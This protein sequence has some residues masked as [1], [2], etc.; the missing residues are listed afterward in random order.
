MLYR[1][2]LHFHRGKGMKWQQSL[3]D[4][5]VQVVR[6]LYSL[7]EKYYVDPRQEPLSNRIVFIYLFSSFRDFLST[8]LWAQGNLGPWGWRQT[9]RIYI[10]H[11]IE[12]E[13]VLLKCGLNEWT[14]NERK[15]QIQWEEQ[16]FWK[17]TM[18]GLS[19]CSITRQLPD[20]GEAHKVPH[21]KLTRH[22]AWPVSS[23]RLTVA[24]IKFSIWW[25]P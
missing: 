5:I 1:N 4:L 20:L 15:R 23:I 19:H 13:R 16:R 6:V 3:Y 18:L 25:T 17:Q 7:E 21:L 9:L 22:W 24:M 10:H 11:A 2:G 8:V 14:M 12:A